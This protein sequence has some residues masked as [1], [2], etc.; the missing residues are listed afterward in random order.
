M[1][2]SSVSYAFLPAVEGRRKTG[3]PGRQPLRPETDAGC[4]REK[5][6]LFLGPPDV[7]L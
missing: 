2:Y 4:K 6:R 7:I 1:L 3:S 5:K